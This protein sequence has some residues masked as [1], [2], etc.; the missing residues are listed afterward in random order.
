MLR[1]TDASLTGVWYLSSCVVVN[2]T[3]DPVAMPMGPRPSGVLI[4]TPDGYMSVHIMA[5]PARAVPASSETGDGTGS[6]DAEAIVSTAS[7]IGYGGRYE[8]DG[9]RLRHEVHW[10]SVPQWLGT[11]QVRQ[12]SLGPDGLL[13]STPTVSSP[14]GPRTPQLRWTRRPSQ[15]PRS[16]PPSPAPEPVASR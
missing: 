12:L 6:G 14:T 2:A 9:D 4:Y 5:T 7:Y 8:R 11:T 10:S 13:L 1:D 3:G 15:P 16:R